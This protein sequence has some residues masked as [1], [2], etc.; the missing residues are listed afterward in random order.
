M[1]EGSYI[2]TNK[3]QLRT[4]MRNLAEQPTD[5]TRADLRPLSVATFIAGLKRKYAGRITGELVIPAREGRYAEFPPELDLRLVVR[6]PEARHR[7]AL[8]T[9]TR[10]LGL[11]GARKV[12]GDRYADGFWE[13]ALL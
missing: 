8:P 4:A 2:L 6:A 13:D 3:N 5:A 11:S 7:T 10:G 12:D 1:I 9:S